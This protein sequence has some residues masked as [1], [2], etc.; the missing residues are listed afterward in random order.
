MIKFFSI[1]SIVSFLIAFAIMI[2]GHSQDVEVLLKPGDAGDQARKNLISDNPVQATQQ[3]NRKNDLRA[4]SQSLQAQIVFRQTDREEVLRALKV[5]YPGIEFTDK[6]KISTDYFSLFT[7]NNYI[8]ICVKIA[9]N[10][11]NGWN[12]ND[13]LTNKKSINT[14]SGENALQE[15][16]QKVK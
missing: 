6:E 10:T 16:R 8:I 4:I 14:T 9:K 13:S 12:F 7:G 15:I 2:T 11:C 5:D 1:F 3:L